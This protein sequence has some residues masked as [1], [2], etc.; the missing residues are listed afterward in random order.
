MAKIVASA[1]GGF[2]VGSV[3]ELGPGAQ[4]WAKG[5]VR[6]GAGGVRLPG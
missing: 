1:E 6:G 4:A 5:A 3:G 2:T